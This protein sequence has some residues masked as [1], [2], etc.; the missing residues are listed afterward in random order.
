MDQPPTPTISPTTQTDNNTKNV[1][2]NYNLQQESNNNFK[3]YAQRSHDLLNEQLTLLSSNNKI[4]NAVADRLKGDTNILSSSSNIVN[5][6]GSTSGLR[7]L[8]GAPA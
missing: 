3:K 7:E 1:L 8:Q 6:F 2:K 4:L 5:N